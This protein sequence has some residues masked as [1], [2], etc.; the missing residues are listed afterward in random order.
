MEHSADIDL[1]AGFPI[2]DLAE[3]GI[4]SGRVDGEEAILVRRGTDYFAVGATCTHYHGAL[5]KGLIVD[6]TIRCP[7]HH[8]CFNYVGHAEKYDTTT[9][10]GTLESHDCA[11]TYRR[12]ERTLAVATISR[13][14]QSLQAERAM[15]TAALE[16]Q[17]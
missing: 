2:A 8:A 6:D 13:D 14:L 16:N 17:E 15:E 12:G 7:L 3:G 11:V 10:E 1:K 4:I 9:I 5:A